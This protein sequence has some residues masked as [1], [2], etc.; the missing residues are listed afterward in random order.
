MKTSII[1]DGSTELRID[2]DNGFVSINPVSDNIQ[3]FDGLLLDKYQVME[4][5]F[6]L[7]QHKNNA[8]RNNDSL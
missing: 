2:S 5:I 8:I 1:K 6:E 3:Y 7:I 4:L